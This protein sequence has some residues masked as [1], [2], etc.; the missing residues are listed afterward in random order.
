MDVVNLYKYNTILLD[1]G[2]NVLAVY[3]RSFKEY[4]VHIYHS[5]YLTHVRHDTK[6]KNISYELNSVV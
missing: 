2:K 3:K 5:E 6:L 4:A 1:V